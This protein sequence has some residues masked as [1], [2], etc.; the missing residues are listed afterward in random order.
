MSDLR[1]VKGT[2]DLWGA[3]QRKHRHVIETARRRATRYGF[4]EVTTPCF[5]FVSTFDR[6]L[7]ETSDAVMKE[8]YRFET[9]GG[10]KVALRP[11]NTAGFA[12]AFISNGWQERLPV[13][14]FYAGPQFRHE[15]PQAGRFRQFTQ[16]GVECLGLAS[17][18]QDVECIACGMDLLRELGLGA[19]RVEVN[20]L[21]SQASRTAYRAA[22][23]AFLTPVKTQLSAESQ[24]RLTKN[25]LRILDSKDPGDQALVAQAPAY[26]DYLNQESQD[27]YAAVKAGL[28]AL[29]IPYSENERLVRGLDYYSHTVFEIASDA[30]GAQ[31]TVLAGGRYDGL[32][33]VMG[34]PP[35]PG[36]GWAAGVDRLAMLVEDLPTAGLSYAIMPLSERVQGYALQAAQKIRQL[37]GKIDS[38]LTLSV[39]FDTSGNLKKRL[40]RADKQGIN[41]AVLIG[42]DEF[43]KGVVT[44]KVLSSGEQQTVPMDK[45]SQVCDPRNIAKLL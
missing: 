23:L 41:V 14:G 12:R 39:V 36:V 38:H 6:T 8:M 27:F 17:P 33:K 4:E 13:R 43:D 32:I 22:L 25:P 40:S 31:S 37:D 29:D 35:T 34:G 24:L 44:L 9:Q 16:I 21:G 45:L 30:L 18:L 26:S 28:E 5:E 7:G 15:R 19:L 1:P 2:R 20:T 10:D 3:E 42:D 11:D